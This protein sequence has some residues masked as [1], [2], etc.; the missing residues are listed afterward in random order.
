MPSFSGQER[1]RIEAGLR[2]TAARLFAAQGVRKTTLDELVAPVGIVKSSFYAF[3]DSKE[4]LYL[5]LMLAQVDDVRS[6]LPALDAPGTDTT[7]ELRALLSQIVEVLDTDPLYRRLISHPDEMARVAAKLGPEQAAKVHQRLLAPL[8]EL[9]ERGQQQRRLV[10]AD[11]RVVL[12]VLQAVLLVPLHAD[13]FGAGLYKPVL[14]LLIDTVTK[15]LR[16]TP[17]PP[18]GPDNAA[19]HSR[20]GGEPQ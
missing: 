18:A 20:P 16:S 9:I 5:E 14:E 12:G 19:A 17:H 4:S 11:P 6:R 2:A 3:F 8:L 10:A 15:G 7:A 1:G 13:E